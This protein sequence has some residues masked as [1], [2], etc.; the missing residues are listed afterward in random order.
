MNTLEHL[1]AEAKIRWGEDIGPKSPQRHQEKI[2]C[3]ILEH[4]HTQTI[5][6]VRERVEA[7]LVPEEHDEPCDGYCNESACYLPAKIERNRALTDLLKDLEAP[8]EGDGV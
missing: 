1:K 4:T 8:V 6:S 3:E 7:K 2:L 5:Q